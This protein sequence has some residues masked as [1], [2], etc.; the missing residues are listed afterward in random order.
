M[1]REL[2]AEQYAYASEHSEIPVCLLALLSS[3]ELT[4]VLTFFVNVPIIKLFFSIFLFFFFVTKI[5][6]ASFGLECLF[7][8]I[9]PP[10][11]RDYRHALLTCLAFVMLGI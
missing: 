7:V 3:R 9:P 6:V 11:F 8:L 2:Y 10:K 5:L 4:V 1:K